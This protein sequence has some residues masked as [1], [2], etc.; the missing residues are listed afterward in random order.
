MGHMHLGALMIVV[1]GVK[2]IVTENRSITTAPQL[3]KCCPGNEMLN[4]VI[5]A[6]A[7]SP[8]TRNR[9]RSSI[10]KA[11]RYPSC[12]NNSYIYKDVSKDVS[13]LNGQSSNYPLDNPDKFCIETIDYQNGNFVKVAIICVDQVDESCGHW[14]YEILDPVLLGLSCLTLS[15]TLF[16]IAF[17]EDLRTLLYGKCLMS[18]VAAM[19]V[20]YLTILLNRLFR[21]A[22]NTVMCTLMAASSLVFILATFFWMNVICYNL[23]IIFRLEGQKR[24]SLCFMWCSLYAWGVPLLLGVF[25]VAMDYILPDKSNLKPR[26]D[27]P[28]CWIRGMAS[29]WLYQ[30]GIILALLLV[31]VAFFC[32]LLI[33]ITAFSN[34]M[35]TTNKIKNI[36]WVFLKMG[37]VM[38]VVWLTE[39]VA[40]VLEECS[41]WRII[42][43]VI[44][45]LQGVYIYLV[46]VVGQANI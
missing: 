39:I 28:H 31:N 41:I 8:N 9:F 30:Y 13:I 19:L 43:D 14:K 2:L 12:R 24:S 29:L 36:G 44:N 4:S 42:F 23:W 7:D 6:C 38:G 37:V 20:A 18:M 34:N 46:T 40:N 11:Y 16:R 35:N 26:L 33:T 22:F 17:S 21:Q 1:V 15:I 5:G 25:M 45:N 27:T 10:F 3:L 32:H